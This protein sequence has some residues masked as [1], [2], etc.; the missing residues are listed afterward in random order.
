MRRR[1]DRKLIVGTFGPAI[2]LAVC[3][4]LVPAWT[5]FFVGAALGWLVVA[6]FVFRGTTQMQYRASIGHLR[7]GEYSEA[8][9]IMDAVVQAEPNDPAHRQF[10]ALLYRLMGRLDD[11]ES[12]YKAVIELEPN[13]VGARIGLAEVYIQGEDY[14]QARAAAL[15]AQEC[16]PHGWKVQYTLGMLADRTGEAAAVVNSLERAVAAGI[17]DSRDRLLVR[18]WLAR[19][20]VRSGQSDQAQ[21]QVV[22][23]RKEADSLDEWR[24]ILDSDQGR[25]LRP[26]L[27]TDINLATQL[28]RGTAALEVLEDL[29]GHVAGPLDD[30][31]NAMR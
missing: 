23:L 29:P 11:A 25:A 4:A 16:D 28:A 10:R 6:Q 30:R 17:P 19:A 18:L 12:D 5:L 1:L 21:Q 22:E 15:A 27:E 9:A 3:G 2:I 14:E 31:S 24:L 7:K 20:Y 26:L 13:G 8:A